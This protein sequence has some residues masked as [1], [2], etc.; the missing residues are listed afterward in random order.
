MGFGVSLILIALGAILYWAI[1]VST[2]GVDINTIGVILMASVQSDSSSRS[3]SGRAGAVGGQPVGTSLYERTKD[4]S[5]G[6]DTRR[7]GHGLARSYLHCFI[8]VLIG[9]GFVVKWLFIAAAIIA[10]IWVIAFFS[11]SLRRA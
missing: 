6:I 9:A 11:G 5:I 2:K 3:S 4:L 7:F 10:L 1:D 8:A